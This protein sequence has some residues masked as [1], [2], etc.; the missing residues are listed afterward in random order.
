MLGSVSGPVLGCW[1]SVSV[2]GF[3]SALGLVFVLVRTSIAEFHHT[4][5]VGCVVGVG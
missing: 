1:V 5:A 3:G 2:L 4:R